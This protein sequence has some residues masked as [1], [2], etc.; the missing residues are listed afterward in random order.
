M[1]VADRFFQRAT[2]RQTYHE[3]PWWAILLV[4]GSPLV[5]LPLEIKVDGEDAAVESSASS[6]RVCCDTCRSWARVRT[7]RR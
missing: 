5:L 2:Y 3:I 6:H 1:R 7:F 4:A